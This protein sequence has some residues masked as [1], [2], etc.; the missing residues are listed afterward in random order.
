MVERDL[1]LLTGVQQL[2]S[3]VKTFLVAESDV[4][5]RHKAALNVFQDFDLTHFHLSSR[6][7][8]VISWWM[9]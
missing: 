3:A 7:A 5:V 2:V 8:I 1:A 9:N 4:E 6:L